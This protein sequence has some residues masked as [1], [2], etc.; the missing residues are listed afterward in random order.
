MLRSDYKRKQGNAKC[1]RSHSCAPLGLSTLVVSDA[2]GARRAGFPEARGT[3]RSL[4]VASG[5]RQDGQSSKRRFESSWT[6]SHSERFRS[7]YRGLEDEA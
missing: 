4:V 5:E 7:S 6:P 2:E 3:S 1:D